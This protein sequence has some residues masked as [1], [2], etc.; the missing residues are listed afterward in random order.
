MRTS[1][2]WAI[3]SLNLCMVSVGTL[4]AFAGARSERPLTQR[5]RQAKAHGKTLADTIKWLDTVIEG[6]S[7]ETN[8]PGKHDSYKYE[9]FRF[10][11][12]TLFW[13]E[14]HESFEG[15]TRLSKTL[16]DLRIPLP[17]L[18]QSSVR[19]DKV[20]ASVY[21]VS[22]TTLGSNTITARSKATYQDGSV[23]TFTSA[24]SGYGVYF[25]NG[26]IAREVARAVVF[27]IRSCQKEQQLQ[28]DSD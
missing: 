7:T 13:R 15:Q 17:G 22:F 4:T 2:F 21:V 23:D 28:P 19:V 12:C 11:G 26:P 5:A 24:R 16:E 6:N 10:E 1:K 8:H 20:G 25:Q 3:L 14:T 18:S 27:S 9:G